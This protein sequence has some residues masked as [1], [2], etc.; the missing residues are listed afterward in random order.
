MDRAQ[1]ANDALSRVT[2][3]AQRRSIPIEIVP[4]PPATSLEH[5]ASLLGIPAA[6]LIKTLVLKRAD[7]SFVFA[8]IPGDR[9]MSWPKLR[10]A[11]A[12]N[13]LALPDA[14]QALEVTGYRRGTITPFGSRNALPVV[15]DRATLESH[16][17]HPITLGSGD[18]NH[19]LFVQPQDL[20]S[21]FGAIVEDISVPL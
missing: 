15:I 5:A 2:L 10:K 17:G 9:S 6:R 16:P 12:V 7:G 18:P 13:K 21:G 4:R 1:E 14:D 11:L 20:V 19:A 3:D 8:L